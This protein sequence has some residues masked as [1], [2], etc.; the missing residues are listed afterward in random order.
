MYVNGG[1]SIKTIRARPRKFWRLP[2]IRQKKVCIKFE[3]HRFIIVEN[4]NYQFSNFILSCLY[5]AFWNSWKKRP[6]AVARSWW[7]L[8]KIFFINY[9]SYISKEFFLV[10]FF[11]LNQSMTSQRP[12]KIVPIHICHPVCTNSIT[13]TVWKISLNF[14]IYLLYDPKISNLW[15]E[16][17][18]FVDFFPK[19]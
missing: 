13:R 2:Y 15:S 12:P 17:S 3:T 9:K 5:R 6:E 1:R 8:Q 14:Q 10:K 16:K 4:R 19:K 11:F 18:S 7:V